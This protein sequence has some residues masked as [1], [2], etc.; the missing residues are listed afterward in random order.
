MRLLGFASGTAKRK[1]AIL[2]TT[3]AE[4]ELPRATLG[5][6][7]L[8]VTS[9]AFGTGPL[10][11]LSMTYGYTVDDEQAHRTLLAVLDSPVRLLDTAAMYGD[12]MAERRIGAAIA[13]HGGLPEGFIVATKVDHDRASGDFGA[14]Q[15][16]RSVER[17]LTLLG[18]DRLQI[19]YLHDPYRITFEEATGPGGALEGLVAAQNEGLIQHLGIAEGG[20]ELARRYVATGAFE[21][22]ITHNRWTLVDRSAAPLIDDA[23]ERGMGVVNAAVFGGGIL[24]QGTQ[25]AAGRY[26]YHRASDV[27]IDRIHAMERACEACGIPLPAAALQFSLREPRADATIVGVSSPEQVS[28]AL[29][30]ASFEVPDAL[31]AELEPLVPPAQ[32]WQH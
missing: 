10:G 23:V 32:S 20:V 9:L 26:A 7:G 13:E 4:H 12:G 16:R 24:V 8:S 28:D 18:L 15:V 2:T 21:T 17:S 22:M 14:S 30:W 5:A 6:T 3:S 11:D 19:A 25:A 31:W 29:R 1:D 27:L